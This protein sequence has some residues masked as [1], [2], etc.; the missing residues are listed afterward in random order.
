M[1][2]KSDEATLIMKSLLK[3]DDLETFNQQHH[4]VLVV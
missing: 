4:E 1:R 3:M 2:R